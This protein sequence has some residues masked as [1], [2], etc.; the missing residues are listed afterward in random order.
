MVCMQFHKQYFHFTRAQFKMDNP[1]YARGSD[2][3][4]GQRS[5]HGQ[6]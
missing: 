6:R 5:N 3:E 1:A 4:F 2:V